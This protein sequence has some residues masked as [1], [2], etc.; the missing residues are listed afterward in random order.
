MKNKMPEIMSLIMS[1]S[2]VAT[3]FVLKAFMG[4]T[5]HKNNSKYVLLL[6]NRS[7]CDSERVRV[8]WNV[9]KVY[10]HHIEMIRSEASKIVREGR[11]GLM[12]SVQFCK[13]KEKV[14]VQLLP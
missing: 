1:V 13:K 2:R 3:L 9:Q 8:C 7:F 6:F 4:L 5:L 10:R 12:L 11:L 14:G